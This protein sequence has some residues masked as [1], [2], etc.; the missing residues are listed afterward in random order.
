VTINLNKVINYQS[1]NFI[2]VP[3]NLHYSKKNG[4]L[5]CIVPNITLPLTCQV[6]KD[7]YHEYREHTEPD[8]ERDTG[9][10]YTLHNSPG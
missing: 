1:F 7:D 5:F 3:F 9:V 8:A 4:T 2:C 6:K 10:L